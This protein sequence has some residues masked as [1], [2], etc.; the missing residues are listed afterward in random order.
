MTSSEEMVPLEWRPIPG[1]PCYEV[2]E[3]GDIRR[4]RPGRGISACGKIIRPMIYSAYGHKHVK[5]A[6]GGSKR[7]FICVHQAV[8]LAFIG[9][10]PIDKDEVAHNDGC[11]WH[12]HWSNLRWATHAENHTDKLLHGTQ[13]I[14]EK[15]GTARLS[16][17]QVRKIKSLLSVGAKQKDLAKEFNVHKG[18]IQAIAAGR[19]WSKIA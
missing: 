1:F 17:E 2:S 3:Y 16:N 9:P 11:A 12:N 7:K 4:S 14:G 19:N 8:A 18:T 6:I 13:L 15:N 5:L 10:K